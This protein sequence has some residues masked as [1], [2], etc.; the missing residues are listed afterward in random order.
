MYAVIE[1]APLLLQGLWTT[2]LVTIFSGA[3]CLV[4]A[5]AA[6][7]ARLSTHRYLRWPAGVFIEVFRGTSLLVQM[8]W[9][10]FALPFFGIQLFPLTAAV[11]ALGLN[12]GAYAAEVVRGAIASRAKGQ[13][14]ACIALGMEPALR[15]RRV[16]IPQSIPAML[17]PFGNVMVDLLKNTSLVSLVTVADLTF[18]AQMIRSTTGQTT[19]IFLTILVIYFIL[20]YLLTLLTSWLERRFALDRKALVAQR[21]ENRLIKVGV[22]A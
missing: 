6:G 9:F 13:T 17:P 4:V 10:F 14:E 18:R 22:D 12:E 7:L 5:F 20:S 8:F 3:L 21:K 15:L 16:I 19:A 1:Y 11:L 2:I